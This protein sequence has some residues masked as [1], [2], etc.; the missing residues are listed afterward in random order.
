L[1]SALCLTGRVAPCATVGIGPILPTLALQQ[2]GSYLKYTDRDANIVA[3]AARDAY[4]TVGIIQ[5]TPQNGGP[6]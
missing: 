6:Y 1:V 4:Q 2:V 5:A 3:T